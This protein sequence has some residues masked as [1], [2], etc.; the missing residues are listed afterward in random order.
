MDFEF[1]MLQTIAI[2]T[3]VLLVGSVIRNQSSYLTKYTI[4]NPVIGG[5]FFS[6]LSLVGYSTGAFFFEFD[7]TLQDVFMT[8]FFTAVGFSSNIKA[9]GRAGK[10]GL[11]LV[12]V[13]ILI[14]II[15]NILGVTLAGIFNLDP[16]IG[17]STGSAALIR[18]EE[19]RVGK[20]CIF[21]R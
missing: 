5:V 15:E 13:I 7:T 9:F 17:L 6:L 2:A 10:I 18:S 20:V 1:D 21:C 12:A 11:Q 16:L 8:V 14:I 3:V 19:R 4:P